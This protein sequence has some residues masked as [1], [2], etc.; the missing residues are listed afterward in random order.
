MFYSSLLPPFQFPIE[1]CR[2]PRMGKMRPITKRP[3]S[4][5]PGNLGSTDSWCERKRRHAPN[6][7]WRKPRPLAGGG[8]HSE[9]NSI[10]D[11]IYELDSD[12]LGNSFQM[13]GDEPVE[14]RR[15]VTRRSPNSCVWGSVEGR[16]VQRPA[17][18]SLQGR[19]RPRREPRTVEVRLNT[20]PPKNCPHSIL[21]NATPRRYDDS[22][23]VAFFGGKA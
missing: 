5:D 13:A 16:V 11:G 23:S 9:F 20:S 8:H 15:R 6:L 3:G 12:D 7:V 19:R 2:I 10:E 22:D 14:S 21:P 4:R 1:R 18:P 17:A